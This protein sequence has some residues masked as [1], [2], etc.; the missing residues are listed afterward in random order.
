MPGVL[1]RQPPRS[2]GVPVSSLKG[3]DRRGY[4]GGSEHWGLRSGP[5][6]VR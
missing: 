5:E 4:A 1:L 3:E 6:E 2:V